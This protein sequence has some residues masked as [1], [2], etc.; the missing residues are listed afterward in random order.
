[1]TLFFFRLRN[2][3]SGKPKSV[4][5]YKIMPNTDLYREKKGDWCKTHCEEQIKN[6]NQGTKKKSSR[7]LGLPREKRPV[8]SQQF[9]LHTAWFQS[10]KIT[11]A[12]SWHN[13]WRS[14]AWA[15]PGPSSHGALD[16]Y[17]H[18][19]QTAHTHGLYT[20]GQWQNWP[21]SLSVLEGKQ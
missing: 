12:F 1:M 2:W 7:F 8:L 16:C 3:S 6:K 10:R 14:Q 13:A 9:T 4:W 15:S 18:A 21:Q 19:V 5:N 17:V 11:T 20:L